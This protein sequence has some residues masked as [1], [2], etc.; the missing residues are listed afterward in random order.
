MAERCESLRPP[1]PRSLYLEAIFFVHRQR[2][3][4]GNE[5]EKAD[6]FPAIGIGL[7]AADSE[8]AEAP[9]YCRQRKRAYRTN[10]AILE[11][12]DHSWES[13]LPV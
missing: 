3:L 2:D 12:L 9:V 1:P 13:N 4:V 7:Y 6:F 8:A 10:P 5:R 11:H